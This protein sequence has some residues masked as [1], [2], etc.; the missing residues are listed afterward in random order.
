MALAELG[1]WGGAG[2]RGLVAVG[3]T[4]LTGLFLAKIQPTPTLMD[5]HGDFEQCIDHLPPNHPFP[6]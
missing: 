3:R 1:E 5:A 4:P 2:A 6:F